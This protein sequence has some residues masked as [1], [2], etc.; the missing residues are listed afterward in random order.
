MLTL[1]QLVQTGKFF[2]NATSSN[3]RPLILEKKRIQ[4]TASSVNDRFHEALDK[5]EVEIVSGCLTRRKMKDETRM[6]IFEIASRKSCDG[7]RP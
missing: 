2:Q 6:L 7:E 4:A 5:I 1:M 3:P